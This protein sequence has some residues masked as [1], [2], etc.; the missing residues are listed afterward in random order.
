MIQIQEVNL[1]NLN[2]RKI[3][4]YLL[5]LFFIE[6]LI[7][8]SLAILNAIS[9]KADVFLKRPEGGFNKLN[10]QDI[11][12]LIF[13][14]ILYL[15]AIY[16]ISRFLTQNNIWKIIAATYGIAFIAVMLFTLTMKL[17]LIN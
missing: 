12:F 17:I 13:Y 14:I 5:I 15:A 16:L 4:G 3:L 8:P 7:S 2:L 6:R 10:M 11:G 9:D 1:Q